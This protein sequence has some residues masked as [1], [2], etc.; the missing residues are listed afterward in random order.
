MASAVLRVLLAHERLLH[1]HG[2][3][4]G[5]ARGLQLRLVA[6]QRALLRLELHRI[7]AGEVLTVG[8]DGR[9]HLGG[10]PGDLHL[11][12]GVLLLEQRQVRPDHGDR[13]VHLGDLIV[14]VPDVLLEDQLGVLH[15]ADEEPADTAHGPLEALPHGLGSP[16]VGLRAAMRRTGHSTPAEAA[17]PAPWHFYA[18][19]G[20]LIS[21]R[22]LPAVSPPARA[23][24]AAWVR[25]SE[26]TRARSRV[27]SSPSRTTCLPSTST[28][29]TSLAR[30]A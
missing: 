15:R 16:S 11:V 14:H 30:Q 23:V 12:L 13:L 21:C 29:R 7:L 27:S 9:L 20:R 6:I 4:V 10:E 28:W 2:L 18:Q 26:T 3:L 19:V 5:L 25:A 22:P 1:V 8:L 17:C 24:V